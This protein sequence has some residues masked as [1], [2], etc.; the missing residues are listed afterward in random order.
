[1]IG[2]RVCVAVIWLADSVTL[3]SSDTDCPA[4]V[5]DKRIACSACCGART[6]PGGHQNAQAWV[7]SNATDRWPIH[8]CILSVEISGI[9]RAQLH[10]YTEIPMKAATHTHYG[11][12]QV[13]RVQDVPTPTAGPNQVLVEV[14]ASPVTEGD[15][16][17]RAADFPGASA[18]VGRLMFGLLRPRNAIPGTVFA[19]RIVAVGPG[20]SRFEVGDDVFGSCDNSAHA[21]YIAVAQDGSVAKIPTGVAYDEAAAVPY[22]AVTALAFLRD[23]ARVKAG[24]RVLIVGAGG[25]VGRFAVQIARHLGAHVTGVGSGRSAALMTELGAHAV[26][27]YQQQ[28]YTRGGQTY[29]VIFDTVSGNGFGAAKRSLT[30]TGRYVS[31]YFTLLIVWQMLLGAVFGGRKAAASVVLGNQALTNEVAELLAQGVIR[32]VI[33]ARYSLADVAQAHA[34]Q[35]G[36]HP[37]GAVIVS[38]R[39]A[40]SDVTPA[41][42]L[43]VA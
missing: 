32:P 31:V 5:S 1:M 27:D 26:I 38:V 36:G 2:G 6:F 40:T 14:H 35:E 16:R 8:I 19:G 10:S 18:V 11:S 23:V 42:P 39:D 17:L 9:I 28:D 25:G 7:Q 21:Q 13:L 12:A 22:G 15:R 30:K 37:M 43:K 3:P 4:T 41:R 34:E 29:D 24:D 20:V 33:A